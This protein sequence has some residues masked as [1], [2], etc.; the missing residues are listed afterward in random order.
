MKILHGGT[1]FSQPMTEDEVTSFLT[2]GRRNI[3]IG[4]LDEKKEPNIHLV[5]YYFDTSKQ[6]FFIE[7][8]KYSK[9]KENLE[10]K[11]NNIFLSR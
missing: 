1:Y 5:W 8:S 9:K 4:T 6:K 3:Y 2:T 10:N 7:T 11:R